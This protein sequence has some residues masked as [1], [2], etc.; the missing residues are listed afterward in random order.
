MMILKK[1]FKIFNPTD[2]DSDVA[3][4]IEE[5]QNENYIVDF[6]D[7]QEITVDKYVSCINLDISCR[8]PER[9]RTQYE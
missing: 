1:I 7:S 2:P 3:M 8:K 5:L 9:V 4:V 6:I